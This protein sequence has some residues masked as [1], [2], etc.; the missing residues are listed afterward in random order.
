MVIM[1]KVERPGPIDGRVAGGRHGGGLI[2]GRVPVKRWD[3][4]LFKT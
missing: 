1:C 2:E 3:R 4:L